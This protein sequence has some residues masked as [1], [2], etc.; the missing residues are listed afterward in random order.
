VCAVPVKG[1]LH[2][3]KGCAEALLHKKNL[4]AAGISLV[5]GVFGAMDAVEIT[6]DGVAIARGLINYSSQ[7]RGPLVH[8]C[9][10]ALFAFVA[11]K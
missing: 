4:Y 9:M 2:V 6:A 7:V 8:V 11:C 1:H 3:D 5:A 10:H